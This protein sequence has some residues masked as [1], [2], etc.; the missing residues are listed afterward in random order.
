MTNL[1]ESMPEKDAA[2]GAVLVQ[3][4]AALKRLRE[5]LS[6][7]ALVQEAVFAGAEEWSNLLS[8]KLVPHLAGDGCLIVA[9]AG[10]TN[11]GKSTVFNLL[12][13]HIVSPIMATA[14]ATARPVIA[15]NPLRAAQCLDG[16]LVPEFQPQ[17]LRDA[18]AVVERT[19]AAN[20]LYV[21]THDTLPDR[22]VLLDTPDV[23]SIEREHWGVADAIRAAGDVLIAVLT[24]EKYKD[25]RVVSFFRQALASGRVIVPV[26]NKANPE[27]NFEIARNQIA[28]FRELVGC[29]AP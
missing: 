12:L 6:S 23:D 29:D 9:V 7:D 1:L 27:K 15:A 5:A 25:D 10:G 28:E 16:K 13:G 20:A 4:D 22:I 11:T 2:L 24:G 19:S 8:Y 3:F 17:P 26:M 14:A 21:A 18:R